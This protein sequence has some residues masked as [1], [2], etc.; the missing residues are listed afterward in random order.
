MDSEERKPLHIKGKIIVAITGLLL[1]L[2]SLTLT[3]LIPNPNVLVGF[4]IF[5]VLIGGF[6]LF[7]GALFMLLKSVWMRNRLSVINSISE[8]TKQPIWRLFKV[9][10]IIVFCV[11]ILTSVVS[12]LNYTC[13]GPEIMPLTSEPGE[14]PTAQDLRIDEMNQAARSSYECNKGEEIVSRLFGDAVLASFF[15]G[16]YFIIRRLTIYVIHGV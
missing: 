6:L 4:L 9:L 16:G 14:T 1:F 3:S 11:T 12:S 13:P 7:G 8:V 5:T 2:S 10:Y 15:I